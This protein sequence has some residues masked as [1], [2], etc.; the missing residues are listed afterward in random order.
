MGISTVFAKGGVSGWCRVANPDA[1]QALWRPGRSNRLIAASLS[2]P[3]QRLGAD[4]CRRPVSRV[5]EP[6]VTAVARSL[7]RHFDVW[8]GQVTCVRG[9]RNPTGVAL[10][11][12]AGAL[13][14]SASSA[15]SRSTAQR[16]EGEYMD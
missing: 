3:L 11:G 1:P 7:A 6:V 2:A 10:R 16:S 5:A 8:H 13:S 4:V 15:S 12:S 14:E 9:C